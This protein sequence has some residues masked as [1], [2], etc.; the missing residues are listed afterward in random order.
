MKPNNL[1][2][3]IAAV[4]ISFH[5]AA[6]AGD[7]NIQNVSLTDQSDF[8]KFAENLTGV[9]GHKTLLPAETLGPLG[10]DLSV[11]LNSVNSRYNFSNQSKHDHKVYLYGVHATKGLPNGFDIGMNYQTLEDSSISSLTGELK[12]GLIDG[13]TVKPS[14]S[15]SGYYTMVNGSDAIDMNSYGIDLGVSKG[16]LNLTPYA[17]V[18][19]ISSNIDPSLNTNLKEE[20]THLLKLSAG[21]NINLFAF[22]LSL[23]FNQIGNQ[24]SY[25]VKAGYRF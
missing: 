21:M 19:W 20:T 10:F 14:V 9:F 12:Y 16:F 23:G 4:I 13:G 8:S 22:D 6:F 3:S 18:G 15:V 17:N 24:D 5:S 7:N 1:I 25:S 2:I 11:S